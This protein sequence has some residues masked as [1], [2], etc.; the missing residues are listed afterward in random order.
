LLAVDA[1]MKIKIIKE[2]RS[3]LGLGLKEVK[4]CNL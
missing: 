2:V 3:I 4:I 1:A